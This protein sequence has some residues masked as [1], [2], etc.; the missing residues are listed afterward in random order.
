MAAAKKFKAP[1][2]QSLRT[3]RFDGSSCSPDI[4]G[5]GNSE[6]EGDVEKLGSVGPAG[7]SCVCGGGRIDDMSATQRELH[8]TTDVSGFLSRAYVSR[9]LNHGILTRRKRKVPTNSLT[10]APM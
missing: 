8:I 4:D 1:C 3:R 10:K 5:Q 2:H 6:A 7:L 9:G